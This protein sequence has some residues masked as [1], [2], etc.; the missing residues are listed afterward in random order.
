MNATASESPRL[1]RFSVLAIVS[2]ATRIIGH[3]SLIFELLANQLLAQ[4][5]QLLHRFRTARVRVLCDPF[6]DLV[7]DQERGRLR[8]D[9]GMQCLRTAQRGDSEV[10]LPI[11]G[12][13]DVVVFVPEA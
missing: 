13:S 5:L 1:H 11:L 12:G 3:R 4:P 6:R 2:F 7:L 9:V 10:Q 8:S